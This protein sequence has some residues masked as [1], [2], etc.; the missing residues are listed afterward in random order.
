MKH[1]RPGEK[2]SGG[3]A[4]IVAIGTIAMALMGATGASAETPLG[5]NA[6]LFGVLAGGS[7]T[8]PGSSTVSWVG[9]SSAGPEVGAGTEAIGGTG[10]ASGWIGG[11]LIASA[12]T[13]PAITVFP[14]AH[15]EQECVTGGG[16]ISLGNGATCESTDTS[17]TSGLLLTL[18]DALV[19]GS[20]YATFLA[21]LTPTTTLG[22]ISLK[23]Y[24]SLT[25][26]LSTGV[27]V[28]SIGN[29]TTA[30]VNTI[31]LSAPSGATVVL[32]ISGTLNLG[33]ATQVF[34]NSGR[35]SPHNLI[36]NIE[37]ANPTFGSGVVLNG[38]LINFT[39]GATT[40]TFG[41]RSG[42]AGAVLTS[43]SV[44]ANAA[45]HVNFWPFTASL[46]IGGCVVTPG[47]VSPDC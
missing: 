1:A 34:A 10:I 43:G 26:K 21:G 30:G 37:S 9:Q 3:F 22:D 42:V 27:N 7:V 24:Q 23:K 47:Q 16:S 32:N 14:H 2:S 40:V 4:S 33:A 15:V 12:I 44:V 18:Q 13:G 28:V 45:T 20:I 39:D 19:E 6:Q 5:P 29:I 46:G 17:G 31:A 41:A 36:W 38:T 25:I 11:D 8:L 35:L